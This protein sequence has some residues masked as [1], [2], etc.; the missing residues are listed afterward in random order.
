MT[1]GIHPNIRPRPQEVGAMSNTT[2]V[3]QSQ[4]TLG[5]PTCKHHWLIETP[6]GTTS[7]GRC[8]RCGAEREFRNSASDYVW[9]DDSGS[10]YRPWRG[11]GG[12]SAPKLFDDD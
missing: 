8:K 12:R 10:G 6:R 11:G 9:E 5:V 1:Y 3:E 4:A 2:V 7:K